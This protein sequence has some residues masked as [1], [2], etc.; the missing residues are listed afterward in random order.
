M[1][2]RQLLRLFLLGAVSLSLLLS[3]P[4]FSFDFQVAPSPSGPVCG[5]CTAPACPVTCV[6]PPGN[7]VCDLQTALDIAACNGEADSINVQ[8]GDYT[9]TPY[10]MGNG[11][12]PPNDITIQNASATLPTINGNGTDQGMNIAFGGTGLNV[13]VRGLI[14]QDGNAGGSNGGALA[15]FIGHTV[16]IDNCDFI[17]N[18]SDT[19][20]GGLYIA[21]GGSPVTVQD[22]LFQNNQSNGGDGGGLFIEF[23]ED[24]TLDNNVFDNNRAPFNDGGGAVIEGDDGNAVLQFNTFNNNTAGD[25]SGGGARV[26]MDGTSTLT[27]NS[28]LFTGNS[29]TSVG[30]GL[31]SDVNRGTLT[32]TN[33]I[34]FMNNADSD[35]GGADPDIDDPSSQ[36][37]MA[38]TNNTV[39][40]NTSGGNGGGLSVDLPGD[41][42]NQ[43]NIF[44]N[45]VFGN[46]AAGDGDDIF[47]EDDETGSGTGSIINLFNNDFTEFVTLCQLGGCTPNVNPQNNISEDPD[48]TDPAGGDFNLLAS[49]PCIDT[50]DP[51]PPDGLPNP[52]FA[53]NPR[54]ATPGTNPDMG[55][56]EFQPQPTPPPTPT[57][58]PTNLLIFG[59]G[60]SLGGG[61]PGVAWIGIVIGLGL[62]GIGRTIRKR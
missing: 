18:D 6:N 56:L 42:L 36:S 26:E 55:A 24:V 5:P 12:L 62:L 50:G 10:I 31:E 40:S 54:P 7:A 1:I 28:N 39:F 25:G 48:L 2:S 61:P 60:C 3:V 13:T 58:I 47:S 16:Q 30:G 8:A 38:I 46:T 41:T 34:F 4:A 37:L 27:V 33:N 20:G 17:G 49:S 32:L 57:P 9:G 23:G 19:D 43:A 45:I 59:S 53:G 14:F 21:P 11:V 22:C 15:L 51:A 35:G 29:A 44:N 52:D